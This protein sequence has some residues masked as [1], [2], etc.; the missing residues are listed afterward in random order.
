MDLPRSA[1]PIVTANLTCEGFQK[2][3]NC[4]S[5]AN[6]Y[7]YKRKPELSLLTNICRIGLTNT[8]TNNVS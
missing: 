2:L 3:N 8:L 4:L 6:G 5:V 1:T 7:C